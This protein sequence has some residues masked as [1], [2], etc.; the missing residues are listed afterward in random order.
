[1]ANICASIVSKANMKK[2][3]TSKLIEW[4]QKVNK[5]TMPWK[6]EKEPYK[7]WISEIILQQTRVG[8]GLLYYNNFIKE[9]PSI[10]SL[11]A[12]PDE[13]VF[14]AWEGLGYYT[15]CKNLLF[16]ARNIVNNLNGRF[17]LTYNDILAL[18]GVGPYTASAISSFAYG[19][20]HAVVDG[21]VFRVLSR[22][23]GEAVPIDSPKGREY[24]TKLANEL[25][26]K[27][28]TAAYNQA[29]MDFGATVCKPK[30]AECGHCIFRKSCISFRQGL[31]NVLPVKE[32]QLVK[33]KRWF[34]YFIFLFGNNILINKRVKKD[35]WENL[36]EFY[37]YETA[38]EWEPTTEEIGDVLYY[39]LNIL[40]FEIKKISPTFSQKLTHQDLKGRFI[41]VSINEIP[42]S[43]QHFIIVN[44]E[45]L[46][47]I[48][49]PKLINQ[50]LQHFL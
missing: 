3:F 8:Q 48:A 46:P 13:A 16:T 36:N 37:L 1:M 9:F 15:R 4:H 10:Q 28:D 22:Y 30:V 11:A 5:R 25:L 42:S 23:F 6:G 35:I 19:L 24:F 21:N 32:K 47:K 26:Y 27:D 41:T 17:P 43:L 12:A 45:E 18:K 39:Q 33:K 38:E 34:T 31:V 40:N 50:Y 49:F 14:K 29:I 44:K 7:I 20:P 2:I